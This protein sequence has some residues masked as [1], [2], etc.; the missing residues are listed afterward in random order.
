M[1]TT[2]N[3]SAFDFSISD[4]TVYVNPGVAEANSTVMFFRG[5]SIPFSSMTDWSSLS[6]TTGYQYSALLMQ[7][8]LGYPDLTCAVSAPAITNMGLSYP[9][10]SQDSSSPYPIGLFLFYTPDSGATSVLSNFPGQD[11]SYSRIS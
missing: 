9:V 7:N 1:L 5:D 2:K 8:F 4:S 3:T 11:F 6:D 10:I